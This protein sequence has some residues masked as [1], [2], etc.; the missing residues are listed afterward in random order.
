[1]AREH[2]VRQTSEPWQR[3]LPSHHIRLANHGPPPHY[4]EA[5]AH[6]D[7]LMRCVGTIPFTIL[8]VFAFSDATDGIEVRVLA[9]ETTFTARNQI[10]RHPMIRALQL[11]T[12]PPPGAR[13]TPLQTQRLSQVLGLWLCPPEMQNR[14][15]I[16]RSSPM[17]RLYMAQNLHPMHHP[18]WRAPLHVSLHQRMARLYTSWV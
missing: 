3:L 6:V 7:A 15:E 4:H 11:P 2:S 10:A 1:M 9:A 17:S 13:H 5:P 12:D 14:S 18:A 16:S 8:C